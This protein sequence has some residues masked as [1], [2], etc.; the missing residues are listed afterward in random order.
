VEWEGDKVNRTVFAS[1]ND[2]EQAAV[3][4][5]AVLTPQP[6][7]GWRA[8]LVSWRMAVIL[9]LGC[10]LGIVAI[11]STGPFGSQSVSAQVSDVLGKSATCNALESSN[12]PS[13]VYRCAVV[14]G[15]N[16]KSVTRCF[17]VANGDVK[18]FVGS[19]RGC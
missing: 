8:F 18:Q 16:A 17:I 9:A 5:E 19:R 7:E 3:A 13:N 6:V 11:I 12:G 14:S 1:T 10:V 2:V 4:Q 15:S